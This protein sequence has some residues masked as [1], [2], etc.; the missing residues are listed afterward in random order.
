MLR[1]NTGLKRH[2]KSY[3]AMS[4]VKSTNL[5]V[6]KSMESNNYLLSKLDS[7]IPEF[8][9]DCMK[10]L[11]T[12]P[13]NNG[14]FG[15]VY[16]CEIKHMGVVCAKKVIRGFQ[17]ELRAESLVMNS[18]SG[19]PCFPYLYGILKPGAILIEYISSRAA[20][21]MVPSRTLNSLIGKNKLKKV[22]GFKFVVS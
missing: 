21:N 20:G 14:A 5:R 12:N 1:K 8:K 4:M 3:V 17:S 10:C 16:L 9:E 18:V 6:K 19:H 7:I 11:T 15:D 2:D 22:H 13:I